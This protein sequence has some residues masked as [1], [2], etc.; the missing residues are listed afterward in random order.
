MNSESLRGS[1]KPATAADAPIGRRAVI[2]AVI[3]GTVPVARARVVSEGQRLV[4]RGDRAQGAL[5]DP[6]GRH[7][8]PMQYRRFSVRMYTRLP[9]NTSE[10]RNGS[11][12]LRAS[13]LY[14]RPGC[15]TTVAPVSLLTYRRSPAS[16]M[17][18]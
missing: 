15:R 4:R 8:S 5:A 10:L 3:A 9:S 1:M 14:P 17:L 13:S 2:E 18:G 12:L 11:S 6:P 16:E 7:H